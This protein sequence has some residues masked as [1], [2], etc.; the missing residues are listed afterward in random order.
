MMSQRGEAAKLTGLVYIS[1][2]FAITLDL[3]LRQ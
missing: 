1:E 2:L 3:E